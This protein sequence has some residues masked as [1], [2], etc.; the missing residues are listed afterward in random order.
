MQ[1][2]GTFLKKWSIR[3]GLNKSEHRGLLSQVL[4]KNG[5]FWAIFGHFW[6]VEKS[7]VSKMTKNDHFGQDLA[8][9]PASSG[10]NWGFLMFFLNEKLHVVGSNLMVDKNA[11]KRGI[12]AAWCR[13]L[14]FLGK[15]ALRNVV[16]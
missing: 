2:H 8:Q 3:P 10:V 13:K 15:T 1:S 6:E 7:T 14:C 11:S 9:I 4:V 12:F 5:H 16:F